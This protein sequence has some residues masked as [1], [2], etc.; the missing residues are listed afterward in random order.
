[1]NKLST[2][3]GAK[4]SGSSSDANQGAALPMA[5]TAQ[6]AICCRAVAAPSVF[7]AS[8]STHDVSIPWAAS[9]SQS[10]PPRWN[11]ARNGP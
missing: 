7:C 3:M 5:S 6:I 2:A 8:Q 9:G 11:S 1:M 10:V 4:T